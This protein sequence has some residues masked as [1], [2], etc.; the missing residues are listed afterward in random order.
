MDSLDRALGLLLGNRANSLP[1]GTFVFVLSDF[2]PAP[3][4]TTLRALVATAW[5]VIPV[6]IQDPL[7]ERSF[8]DISGVTVPLADTQDGGHVLV[9]LSRKEARARREANELRA[10]ELDVELRELGV[11]V[12]NLTT[13]DRGAI[14][15]AFLAWASRRDT[16]TRR[17]R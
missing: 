12:V 17:Y 2:L 7:W 1:A 3:S 15:S 13:A 6:V 8:P 9:R 5:D 14:H 4:P 16:Q 11:D 10:T